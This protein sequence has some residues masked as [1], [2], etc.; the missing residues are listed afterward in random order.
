LST[1]IIFYLNQYKKF[2][3]TKIGAIIVNIGLD[4]LS[5]LVLIQN[6]FVTDFQKKT[7]LNTLYPLIF[8][9]TNY[10]ILSLFTSISGAKNKFSKKT[11][12]LKFL[13]TN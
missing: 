8:E 1:S 10:N 4:K 5:E 2:A 3:T 12:Q 13:S 9:T 11:N 7:I 6:K